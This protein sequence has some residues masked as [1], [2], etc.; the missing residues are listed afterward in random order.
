MPFSSDYA[1]I[2]EPLR[3]LTKKDVRFRWTA[4]QQEVFDQ[5]DIAFTHVP[6]MHYF[7][8]TKETT[9]T[10]DAS[11]VSISAILSQK[12]DR[13]NDTHTIAY[14]SRALTQVEQRYSQTEIEAPSIVWAVEHY[15]LNLYGCSFTL[16]T[17]YFIS[18]LHFYTN[19]VGKKAFLQ[20][21]VQ[22][23]DT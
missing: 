16:V 22:K 12:D 23:L 8:T 10:V 6:V 7:D 15:H 13:S 17:D 2:T 3:A 20:L 1:T 11:P 18:F 5:L 19:S 21:A 4:A 14:A 9:L